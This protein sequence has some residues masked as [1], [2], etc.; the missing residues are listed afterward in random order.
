M[1]AIETINKEGI[2]KTH[3]YRNPNTPFVAACGR[4]KGG[5]MKDLGWVKNQ[6]PIKQKNFSGVPHIQIGAEIYS[7]DRIDKYLTSNALRFVYD[8]IRKKRG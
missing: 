6:K 5:I 7:A 8:K 3:F 2:M 4:G 1:K